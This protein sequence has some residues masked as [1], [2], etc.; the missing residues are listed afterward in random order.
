MD[1]IFKRWIVTAYNSNGGAYRYMAETET[2]AQN[3][4]AIFLD[5]NLENVSLRSVLWDTRKNAIV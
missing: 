3:N 2:D 1:G 4:M 5:M